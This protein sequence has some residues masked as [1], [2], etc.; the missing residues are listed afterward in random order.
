MAKAYGTPREY[1]IWTIDAWLASETYPTWAHRGA[2]NTH[3]R[4]EFSRD[5]YAN[6]LAVGMRALEVSSHRT[7]DG[8]WVLSHNATTGEQYTSDLTIASTPWS[9]LQTLTRKYG[10]TTEPMW[11]LQGILDAYAK[12]YVL[13]VENKSYANNTEFYN[14]CNAADPTR[15][16]IVMKFSGDATSSIALG[17]TNGYTTWGY[18]FGDA[19]ASTLPTTWSE[20]MDWVGLSSGPTNTTTS[21]TWFDWC[22]ARDIPLYSHIGRTTADWTT[23]KAQ[24]SDGMTINNPALFRLT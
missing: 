2:P 24:G 21:Q 17:K 22:I 1:N 16:H 6:A 7:S 10:V 13:V 9:T 3:E 18:Y 15:T 11:T 14:I 4:A 5:T 19:G 12:K 20:D 23:A 8:V